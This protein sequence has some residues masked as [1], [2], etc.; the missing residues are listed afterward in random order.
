V[1]ETEKISTKSY[2]VDRSIWK[3]PRTCHKTD[4]VM[5]E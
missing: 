2:S 4:Y 5:N 1:L 3:M